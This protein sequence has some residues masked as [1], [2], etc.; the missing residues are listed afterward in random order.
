MP[1]NNNTAACN[2]D[3]FSSNG[4]I[5]W[6]GR[7]RPLRWRKGFCPA[8]DDQDLRAE[9]DWR[10]VNCYSGGTGQQTIQDPVVLESAIYMPILYAKPQLGANINSD[11]CATLSGLIGTRSLVIWCVKHVISNWLGVPTS[12]PHR[13]AVVDAFL[14][15]SEQLKYG[16]NKRRVTSRFHVS[17]ISLRNRH[18]SY[19]ITNIFL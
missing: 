10:S 19:L 18:T 11:L 9:R 3:S 12:P 13:G 2:S 4:K 8:A 17:I 6:R 16:N 15:L 1:R 5:G 7:F 14:R